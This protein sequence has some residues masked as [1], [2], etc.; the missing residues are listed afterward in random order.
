MRFISALLQRDY[1]CGCCMR[2]VR[3]INN[4]TVSRASTN[5]QA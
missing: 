2:S 3:Q 5:R 4:C 1:Q